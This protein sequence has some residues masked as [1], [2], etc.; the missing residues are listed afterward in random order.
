L[1]YPAQIADEIARDHPDDVWEIIRRYLE[2]EDERSV[3]PTRSNCYRDTDASLQTE[4]AS[5]HIYAAVDG[6]LLRRS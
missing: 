2:A 1:N 5:M 3:W 4:L 6:G